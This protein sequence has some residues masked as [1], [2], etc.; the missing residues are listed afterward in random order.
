[1]L[2]DIILSIIHFIVSSVLLFIALR[3][4]LRTK[5]PSILYY[6]LGFAII[7]VGHILIDVFFYNNIEMWRFDE[8]FDLL[9]FTAFIL[10]LKKS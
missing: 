3:A 7:A 10:A 6:F 2:E 8:I 1:M 5:L 4:Y 9:G